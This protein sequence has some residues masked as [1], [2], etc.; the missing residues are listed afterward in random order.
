MT[1]SN[2]HSERV[3]SELRAMTQ[4]P[5]GYSFVGAD[6]DSQVPTSFPTHISPKGG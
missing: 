2:A 3:G 6:V 5:P 4:A 1:A